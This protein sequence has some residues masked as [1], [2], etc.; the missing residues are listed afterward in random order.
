[1]GGKSIR[2]I[3]VPF[4][5]KMVRHDCMK[6]SIDRLFSEFNSAKK[7]GLAVGVIK[8]REVVLAK[9]YGVA[10]LETGD[11]CTPSTNFRLASLTKQFTAMAVMIL[12][13]QRKLQLDDSLASLFPEYPPHGK[14]IT[15]RHLL[16]HRSGLLDY[17]E[18][19]PAS[20]TL[21]IK[22]KDIL[23]LLLQQDRTYFAP[24]SAFRYS[25]TG[26]V[27]LALVVEK[28]SG[29]SFPE[30]LQ[31]NIFRPLQMKGTVAFE[32]GGSE[33][34]NRALGYTGLQQTDQSV[35]SATLGDGG[36]YSSVADLSLW[37]QSLYTEQLVSAEMLQQAF[38]IGSDTSDFPKT[39]YGFG[40]YVTRQ[41]DV[42]CLWHY[43][44]TCGFSSYIQRFPSKGLTVILL[45][46]RGGVRLAAISRTLVELFWN[47]PK[48]SPCPQP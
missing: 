18:L 14:A 1:M 12:A 36:I 9:G 30:F 3:C 10:N 4:H 27:L 41:R 24:D 22:D 44:E 33:V 34:C 19:I 20:A 26:Y 16:T 43:G 23:D 15:L 6:E 29:Q 32:K 39:G 40:W 11:K 25:N 21:Q 13:E 48:P 37:D 17:E 45:S 5:G 35:T 31:E 28:I 7:P 47:E 42:D 46:N 8:N 38:A 2:L